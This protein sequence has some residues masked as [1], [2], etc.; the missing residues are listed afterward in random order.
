MFAL[1]MKEKYKKRNCMSLPMKKIVITL[2]LFLFFLHFASAGF[3]YGNVSITNVRININI[4]GEDVKINSD[5]TLMNLGNAD[6][7][8]LLAFPGYPADKI[9]SLNGVPLSGALSIKTRE[10]KMFG[11]SAN[12]KVSGGN[13]MLNYDP[14]VY[15]NGGAIAKGANKIDTYLFFASA[16]AKITSSKYEFTKVPASS[17][18]YYLSSRTDAFPTNAYIGWVESSAK[19]NVS[20]SISDVTGVGS[21]FTVIVKV[22]NI[23]EDSVSNIRLKDSLL[24][25]YFNSLQPQ[26]DFNF[27]SEEMSDSVYLWE[28]NISSLAPGQEAAFQY[29]GKIGSLEGIYFVPLK[30]LVGDILLMFYDGPGIVVK[31]PSR[32]TLERTGPV[33]VVNKTSFDLVV[34][35]KDETPAISPGESQTTGGE[36]HIQPLLNQ[37]GYKE[38]RDR[39]NNEEKAKTYS[40]Y[41]YIFI[42]V[43]LVAVII[44]VVVYLIKTLR[45]KEKKDEE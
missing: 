25:R 39:I 4:S 28:K 7:S 30:V 20:R 29:S 16:N 19:L 40:K 24:A 13:K 34:V 21:N 32:D 22:K 43:V 18:Q 1:K 38:L 17:G 33:A 6:E 45:T 27:I 37:N 15:I 5:Y 3:Y 35:K 2:A 42:V 23:G 31:T 10:T 41:L 12:Y 36:S 26:G 14:D 9:V 8:V 44:T 11:V